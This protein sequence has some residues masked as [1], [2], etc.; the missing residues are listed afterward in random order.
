MYQ[1]NEIC[2]GENP[3]NVRSKRFFFFFLLELWLGYVLE[4][5]KKYRNRAYDVQRLIPFPIYVNITYVIKRSV[6]R[7]VYKYTVIISRYV[8]NRYGY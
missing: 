6:I 1:F 4:F 8:R 2:K 5:S 3:F 7:V